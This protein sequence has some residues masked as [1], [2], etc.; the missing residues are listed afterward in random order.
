MRLKTQ[1][2]FGELLGL[3]FRF[4]SETYS[5]RMCLMEWWSK[6]LAFLGFLLEELLLLLAMSPFFSFSGRCLNVVKKLSN[7]R[8]GQWSAGSRGP[9][10]IEPLSIG[11]EG[12]GSLRWWV[13]RAPYSRETEDMVNGRSGLQSRP[14]T[15]GVVLERHGLGLRSH[16]LKRGFYD[17]I[18]F[19][20]KKNSYN[21]F[22]YH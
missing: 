15:N 21:I 12:S 22:S 3:R 17:N 1:V 16:K 14:R 10:I 5:S 7:L 8:K 13:Y 9:F 20:L 11:R 18:I 4:T 6:R 2:Q 19:F